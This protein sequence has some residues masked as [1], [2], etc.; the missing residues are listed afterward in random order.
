MKVYIF[1]LFLAAFFLSGCSSLML[2]PGNFAWPVESVLPVDSQG[3]VQSER[4]SFSLNVKALLFEETQDSMSIPKATVR[5]IRNG[6]GYFFMTG[7]Q[8]KN[9]YVFEQ[10][11]GS[12]KLKTKIPVSQNGLSDPAMNQRAPYI[13]LVNGKD[14][15]LSLSEEG[16][17]EGEKK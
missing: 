17:V 3:M 2:K 10:T 11:E 7:R 14:P 13:Q 8:F 4:Y 6:K 16:I 5:V 9:V 12:L 1:P 15:A